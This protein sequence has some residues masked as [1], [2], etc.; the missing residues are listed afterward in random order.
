M[1]LKSKTFLGIFPSGHLQGVGWKPLHANVFSCASTNQERSL[2]VQTVFL[3]PKYKYK[4]NRFGKADNCCTSSH[5]HHNQ[6][7]FICNKQTAVQYFC[8][9]VRQLTIS[10]VGINFLVN[11]FGITKQRMRNW[12]DQDIHLYFRSWLHVLKFA[13]CVNMMM[14][15]SLESLRKDLTSRLSS[16]GVSRIFNLPF[17]FDSISLCLV[18]RL[19]LQ[20]SLWRNGMKKERVTHNIKWKIASSRVGDW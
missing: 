18:L 3:P 13:L 6:P 1:A 15:R 19:S 9:L 20:S 10:V 11:N 7:V 17:S 4:Q 14:R 5:L 12:S 16:D 8:Y 2:K